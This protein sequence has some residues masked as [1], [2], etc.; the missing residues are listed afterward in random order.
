MVSCVLG[1]TWENWV[2]RLAAFGGQEWPQCLS[3]ALLLHFSATGGS[4][5]MLLTPG[6]LGFRKSQA[7]LQ[8]CLCVGLLIFEGSTANPQLN[9]LCMVSNAFSPKEVL[10]V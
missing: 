3:S 7:C 10:L 6:I 4:S 9:C 2:Q 5:L 1:L 8:S